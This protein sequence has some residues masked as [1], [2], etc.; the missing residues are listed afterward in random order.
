MI[1]TRR[2]LLIGLTGLIAA[3]AIVRASSL[4]KVK[5]LKHAQFTDEELRRI[6]EEFIKAATEDRMHQIAWELQRAQTEAIMYGRG[7]LLLHGI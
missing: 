1:T 4:M 7:S 3:P 2:S 5:T 6:G